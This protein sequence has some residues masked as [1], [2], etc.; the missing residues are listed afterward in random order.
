MINGPATVMDLFYKGWQ[1]IRLA[2]G[3]TAATVNINIAKILMN[4]QC[5]GFFF[6]FY[7]LLHC[8]KKRVPEKEMLNF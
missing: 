8:V 1:H 5:C 6:S 3:V 7:Y 4:L 2:L